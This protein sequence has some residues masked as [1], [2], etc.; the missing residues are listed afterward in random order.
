MPRST[1]RDAFDFG[2]Q[3]VTGEREGGRRLKVAV[4]VVLVFGRGG[5]VVR[6]V[7]GDEDVG[8]E[9]EGFERGDVEDVW[10]AGPR[11]GWPSSSIMGVRPIRRER[12]ERVLSF[13]D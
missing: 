9:G 5:R 4:E 6:M 3:Y 12:R 11:V 2:C 10:P 1:S 13:R 8:R 7:R